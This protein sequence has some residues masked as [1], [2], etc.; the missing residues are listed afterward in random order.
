MMH[1]IALLMLVLVGLLL[2]VSLWGGSG[3]TQQW[4]DAGQSDS[5]AGQEAQRTGT[6]H[7]AGTSDKQAIGATSRQPAGA[8]RLELQLVDAQNGRALPDFLVRVQGPFAEP[9]LLQSDGDG[10]VRS[11][12]PL[13]ASELTLHLIDH[14]QL[15]GTPPTA[16]WSHPTLDP[17]LPVAVGPT[18]TLSHALPLEAP[19]HAVTAFLI[20]M[21][22]LSG[23]LSREP[24]NAPLRAGE[25]TWVRFRPFPVL[26]AQSWHLVASDE[27]GE[28]RG[29]C[30]L[31]Q[32]HGSQPYPLLLVMQRHLPLT[33]RV[34]H[35][36]ASLLKDLRVDLGVQPFQTLDIQ[37][38]LPTRKGAE[39]VW[40]RVPLG[41][42]RLVVTG[43]RV[44]RTTHDIELTPH[45]GVFEVTPVPAGE[46][47]RVTG[48]VTLTGVRQPPQVQLSLRATGD[49]RREFLVSVE[50]S[51]TGPLQHAGSFAFESVPEGPWL[52]TPRSNRFE[53]WTPQQQEISAPATGLKLS[54]VGDELTMDLVVEVRDAAS[55]QL[56][57]GSRV[58]LQN[59]TGS[60]R[61]AH[62][63][64]QATIAA[65]NIPRNAEFECRVALSGYQPWTGSQLDF[66]E[67]DH[68][69]GQL[70]RKARVLLQSLD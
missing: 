1:R 22:A 17:L 46:L 9:I 56:L 8:Q 59:Q 18:Y 62:D 32:V 34:V 21:G 58:T 5:E 6:Q 41:R 63:V 68:R 16:A 55:G 48:S 15:P 47:G 33:V 11:P 7:S 52:L 38:S 42:Y 64:Q 29:R 10:W 44:Q 19:A 2:W 70:L 45:A 27:T 61:T 39:L 28:W 12:E 26:S 50:W 3:E 43:P 24:P 60:T 54:G 23:S 31:R 14:P 69:E 20:N 65:R 53:V 40:P 67:E 25:P 30:P 36:D 4:P 66:V 35:E 37:G 49:A 13:P 51:E 57:N